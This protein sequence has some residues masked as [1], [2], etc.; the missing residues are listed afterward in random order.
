MLWLLRISE[1]LLR[2]EVLLLPISFNIE[3]DDAPYPSGECERFYYLH[4]EVF[5]G[6]AW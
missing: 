6:R 3:V 1:V 5:L 2:T 4:N